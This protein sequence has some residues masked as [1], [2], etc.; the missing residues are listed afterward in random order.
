M[1][2]F[3]KNSNKDDKINQIG[4]QDQKNAEISRNKSSKLRLIIMIVMI[5][6]VT[7]TIGFIIYTLIIPHVKG[8]D[9][10]QKSNRS[11]VSGPYKR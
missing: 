8:I 9:L 1:C 11:I 4:D 3:S 10:Q 6:L 7:V 2:A 5:L